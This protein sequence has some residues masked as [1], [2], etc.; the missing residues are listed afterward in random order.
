M[1]DG[2]RLRKSPDNGGCRKL[3][4]NSSAVRMSASAG[5]DAMTIVLI[6]C[7]FFV[8]K[9]ESRDLKE[10]FFAFKQPNFWAVYTSTWLA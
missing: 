6:F 7:T 1:G 5:A 3:P 2:T 10:I 4:Q 9:R 8:G